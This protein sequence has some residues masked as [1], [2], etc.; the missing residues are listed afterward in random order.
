MVKSSR[1]KYAQL[2]RCVLTK[3]KGDAAAVIVVGRDGTDMSVTEE[4]GVA[5]SSHHIAR[6]PKILRRIA[7]EIEKTQK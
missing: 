5:G 6:L 4:F 2:C 1:G 7:D 3:S